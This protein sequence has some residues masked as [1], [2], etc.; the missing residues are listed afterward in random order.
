MGGILSGNHASRTH[1]TTANTIQLDS[2]AVGREFKKRQGER[3]L[4]VT[5]DNGNNL[6]IY[7]DDERF[8]DRIRIVYRVNPNTDD[9]KQ[10]NEISAL[11]WQERNFGGK[12]AYFLC[13]FCGKRVQI[14]YLERDYFKCRVC[15]KLNY[16]S[17]QIAHGLDEKM[18]RLMK[19]ALP[20]GLAGIA[21]YYLLTEHFVPKKPRG[22]H[23]K[24]YSK[25]IR[26]YW[27]AL[28]AYEAQ[29]KADAEA[30]LKRPIQTT[31]SGD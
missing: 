28:D 31:D 23:G 14:L 6:F 21:P 26:A 27:D 7:R 20:L 17:Q 11:I 22:M 30:I 2:F 5:W 24:T 15:A 19:A 12:C 3:R 1:G 10:I 16:T 4:K 9:E 18:Y 29:F 13:P 8:E 25:L